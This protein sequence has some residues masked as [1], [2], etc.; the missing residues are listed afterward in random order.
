MQLTIEDAVGSRPIRNDLEEAYRVWLLANPGVFPLFERFALELAARGQRFS[1]SLL[2]ERIR[3][4]AKMTLEADADQ[5]KINN[6]YR[7]YLARDLVAKYPRLEPL[8]T[9]RC[10]KGDEA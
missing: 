10:V 7:A 3:W 5:F 6:S 1:I 9:L 8:M 2:T 4:E